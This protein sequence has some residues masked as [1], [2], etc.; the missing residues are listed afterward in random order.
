MGIALRRI[1]HRC[2]SMGCFLL[3]C[4]LLSVLFSRAA[5]SA[6]EE[7]KDVETKGS[8]G[9]RIETTGIAASDTI[10]KASFFNVKNGP[11]PSPGQ[12]HRVPDEL[13]RVSGD[14]SF[15]KK[16]PA[17]QYYI[18]IIL[19]RT[20]DMPGPPQAGEKSFVVHGPDNTPQVF[21]VRAGDHTEA[22]LVQGR[23]LAGEPESSLSFFTVEGR[24]M[25]RDGNPVTETV[26]VAFRE[27][28]KR[29]RPEVSLRNSDASGRYSMKLAVGSQ[30]TIVVRAAYGGGVPTQGEFVGRY[31]NEIP[32][33]VSG[34][35]D[36]VV[37]GIDITVFEVPE[38]GESKEKK[39]KKPTALYP[40]R[41]PGSTGTP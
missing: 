10:G 21:E 24:I 13:V 32:K 23:V 25:D 5:V 1:I 33:T 22:G 3:F 20:S 4:L 12:R 6:A 30:Y 37:S 34:S 29:L 26:I 28:E 15:F 18:G 8:I 39:L 7:G 19:G 41:A 16:L 36:E 17:G 38:P 35:K 2:N 40:D 14:G 27:G 9:G 11:P 31:G